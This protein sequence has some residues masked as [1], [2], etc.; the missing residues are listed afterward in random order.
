MSQYLVCVHEV[1]LVHALNAWPGSLVA[2]TALYSAPADA[3]VASKKTETSKSD[4][5]ASTAISDGVDN[6]RI[7]GLLASSMVFENG[8]VVPVLTASLFTTRR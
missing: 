2:I 6:V 7:L 1:S 5:N 4:G 3:A 8:I